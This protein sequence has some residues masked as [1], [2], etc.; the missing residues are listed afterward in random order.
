MSEKREQA[1]F[2]QSAAE[3]ISAI[4]KAGHGLHG[5]ILTLMWKILDFGNLLHI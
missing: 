5:L 4:L 1:D 2:E 3:A